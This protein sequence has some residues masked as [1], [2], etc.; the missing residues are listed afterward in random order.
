MLEV[1]QTLDNIASKIENVNKKQQEWLD[2]SLSKE[3]LYSF[4]QDN[5]DLFTTLEEV[6]RFLSGE[7]IDSKRFIEAAEAEKTSLAGLY[8][9]QLRVNEAVEGS[10][11]YKEA[12]ADLAFY[13]ALL[14]HTGDLAML[15]IEQQNY[16][17][18]LDQYNRLTEIGN[19]TAADE[20]RLNAAR[21]TY[22]Q[23]VANS[24]LEGMANIKQQFGETAAD[25]GLLAGG[26]SDYFTIVNGTVMPIYD[27]MNNL[28][29]AQMDY[30]DEMMNNAQD[31]M[32]EAFDAFKEL[33]DKDLADEKIKL[34]EQ[35]S[36]Y[37]DYF[38]ALDRLESQR[39]SKQTR[40]EIVAQLQRLEG[41]TDEVS[42]K[43]ALDLKKQLNTLDDKDA[44]QMTKDSRAD[45]LASFDTKYE[46]LEANW[47]LAG[48]QFISDMSEG[49]TEAGNA[50]LK[51]LV[52][53]GLI[54]QEE[55]DGVGDVGSGSNVEGVDPLDDVS[56]Q[57]AAELKAEERK[58]GFIGDELEAE[59]AA[60]KK[61]YG[62]AIEEGR[63]TEAQVVARARQNL[64][65]L[66]DN[67]PEEAKR[68][69]IE[70]RMNDKMNSS[71]VNR[72]PDPD[73]REEVARYYLEK[74]FK[75]LYGY[76]KGGLADF[77]GLA[78][79]HGTTRNPEAVLSAQQTE[80]FF[81]LRDALSKMSID[82]GSSE[83]IN[84]EKIEIKTDKLN[85]TQDFNKAGEMLAKAFS[86][87]IKNR[88]VT[89]N[90]KR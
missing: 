34:K 5:K 24:S 51:V 8:D 33:R 60:V 32:N 44:A 17:A 29:D 45:M 63:M 11:E 40:A 78:Q 10:T 65:D 42:R 75:D 27:E 84:I 52:D 41:A 64:G 79:M 53:A 80:M 55:A 48:Q 68:R 25:M 81:G 15:T 39:D 88:G 22:V 37:T 62:R 46:E 76:S 72:I 23:T 61:D 74:E 50:M 28:T 14:Q 16:N 6:E 20:A 82:G 7:R 87:S 66:F 58:S 85:G 19:A 36:I 31:T 3:D 59:I 67:N 26:F 77:T 18:E 54:T 57:Q 12:V 47:A 30:L 13:R 4:I 43:K 83:S 49:G 1:A 35:K 9:A 86:K 38:K 89:V 73:A 71:E 69:W 70:A 2:G 56:L 21:L 90:S